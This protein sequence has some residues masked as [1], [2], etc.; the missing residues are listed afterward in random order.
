MPMY[1]DVATS[2]PDYQPLEYYSSEE[3][4]EWLAN[5]DGNSEPT[6]RAEVIDLATGQEV[7]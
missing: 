2:A 4:S 1:R 7:R 6:R 5:L 3:P